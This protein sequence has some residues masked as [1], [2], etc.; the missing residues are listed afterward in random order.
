MWAID[1]N[2]QNFR[3]LMESLFSLLH[4]HGSKVRTAANVP[5]TAFT[6]L[7]VDGSKVNCAQLRAAGLTQ[8]CRDMDAKPQPQ[9][10]GPTRCNPHTQSE[11]ALW[12]GAVHV[13]RLPDAQW[14]NIYASTVDEFARLC[15]IGQPQKSSVGWKRPEL[16][17]NRANHLR[18]IAD[19][20]FLPWGI[21]QVLYLDNDICPV[22]AVTDL[23]NIRGH[24]AV[25]VA[26]RV[27]EEGQ[28]STTYTAE[29]IKTSLT[30]VKQMRFRYS[31]NAGVVLFRT[32]AMCEYDLMGKIIKVQKYHNEVRNL[33]RKGTNQPPF[34]VA[35]GGSITVVDPWWNCRML[36]GDISRL[37]EFGVGAGSPVQW[38][39]NCKLFHPST[40]GLTVAQRNCSMFK[41][42]R[43]G[44]ARPVPG[45]QHKHHR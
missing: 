5:R 33:W 11:D 45:M 25:V 24:T 30:F 23:M 44:L 18:F 7:A 17:K 2:E 35:A 4:E 34:E 36:N 10:A 21:E 32:K 6:V 13:I 12:A 1:Q 40:H 31:F 38:F 43:D 26:A 3:R 19:R 20:I 27:D 39:K 42:V 14:M 41:N 37:M 29:N 8:T 15:E 16:I 22:D 28:V 9:E